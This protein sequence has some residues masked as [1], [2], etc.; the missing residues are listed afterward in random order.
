MR[1][2]QHKHFKMMSKVTGIE[3]ADELQEKGK[4][5]HEMLGAE[6]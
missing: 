4:E 1:A 2:V 6:R 5:G 3:L